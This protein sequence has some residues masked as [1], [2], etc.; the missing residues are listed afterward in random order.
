TAVLAANQQIGEISAVTRAMSANSYQVIRSIEEITKSVSL[1]LQATQQMTRQ[2]DD[3]NKAFSD[4][5][6][7]SQQNASSVEVLT[8]VNKEVTDAAQR[9]LTSVE[10]MNDLAGQ[11]DTRLGHFKVNESSSEEVTQ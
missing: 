2:S 9:M 4:I 10:Q 3:V 5:S 11:I 6:S 7:I 8:Y 1:N